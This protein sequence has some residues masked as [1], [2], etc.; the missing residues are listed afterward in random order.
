M[1]EGVGLFLAGL[2]GGMVNAIAGGGSCGLRRNRPVHRPPLGVAL[3]GSQ[4]KFGHSLDERPDLHVLMKWCFSAQL[5][6]CWLGFF[7]QQSNI[8]LLFSS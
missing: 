5:K 1:I 7:I 6:C 2:I 8:A 3:P 4:K